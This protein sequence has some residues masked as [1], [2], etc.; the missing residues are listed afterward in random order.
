VQYLLKAGCA[1]D[2]Y[3]G[4]VHIDFPRDY[5]PSQSLDYNE[6]GVNAACAVLSAD[7]GIDVCWHSHAD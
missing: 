5:P 4:R 6:A 3:D 1:S 2:P 7:L